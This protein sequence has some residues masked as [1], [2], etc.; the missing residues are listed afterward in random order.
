MNRKLSHAAA[1]KI[2]LAAVAVLSAPQA[3]GTS[4]YATRLLGYRPAPG[5]FMNL[6]ITTDSLAV[7]GP[8][9]SVSDS[10][11]QATSGLV[12]LGNFGGYL[13]LAFDTPV[14]NNPQNPYGVDFTIFGNSIGLSSCEPAAVQVMVDENGNGLPDDG[15]WLELAGS[16]Y[17]LPSTRHNT[18]FTYQN[19][20]YNVAH[21]VPFTTNH[22]TSGAVLTADTHTQPYYPDPFLF[23]SVSAESYSLEG[24]LIEGAVDMRNPRNITFLKQPA[25]GYA[26]NHLTPSSIAL[27][28]PR[29][30]YFADENGAP[31]DG[32]DISWAVDGQGNHVELERIDFIRIYNPMSIN[33]G[34]LGET[35]PE[36]A[37]V[38]ITEP[39]PNYTPRDYWLNYLYAPSP[40]VAKGTTVKLTGMLFRNGRPCLDAPAVY[41]VSDPSVGTVDSNGNFTALAEG[42]TTVTFSASDEAPADEIEICVTSLT[43]VGIDLN[44]KAAA[45][46]TA[47]CTVG[48]KLYIPV[49]SL[50]NS[51]ELFGTS[52][53]SNRYS[54][55]TY[56]WYNTR[57]SVGTVDECGTFTAL[58]SGST[59]LTVESQTDPSLYAE[60]KITVKEPVDVSLRV[61]ELTFTDEAPAGNLTDRMLFRTTD[62]STVI[63]TSAVPRNAGLNLWLKGNRICYDFSPLSSFS[64]ILDIEAT[65]C[66]KNLSFEIPVSYTAQT[67]AIV[68]TKS[69]QQQSY[70]IFDLTG[71]PVA[72]GQFSSEIALPA[73]LPKGIYILRSGDTS[74]KIHN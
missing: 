22:S 61:T 26:D 11:E 7:L 73:T 51:P 38:V 15:P 47:T 54:A 13:I 31:A 66:G 72:N 36:I 19:P 10:D 68:D 25:F 37:G 16:D 28:G 42:K 53:S 1:I 23:E 55:D 18:V 12:S 63:I 40:Q 43:G 45:S 69:L 39:D 17:W 35:S 67:S 64:D 9:D 59:V 33:R 27:S 65:H 58:K 41:T 29:N 32:F 4:R 62:N 52:A 70:T 44:N 21:Q 56:T 6:E 34:W 48:G 30:P 2:V 74:I 24:T 14:E 46:A 60:I 57:P 50:D 5:Q 49:V 3:T 71:T 20:L 8:V